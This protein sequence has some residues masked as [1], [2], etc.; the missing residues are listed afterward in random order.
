MADGL[1]P[2]ASP[3]EVTEDP[4]VTLKRLRVPAIGLLVLSGVT[5]IPG[6]FCLPVLPFLLVHRFIFGYLERFSY[7]ADTLEIALAIPMIIS[8]FAIFIGSWNMR[9]GRFYK[10]AYSAAVLSCIPFLSAGVY[11]GIPFGIWALIVLHRRDVKE[12]FA[13]NAENQAQKIAGHESPVG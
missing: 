10:L 6:I 11:L 12:A 8:N 9:R 5:A 13:R 7:K 1:N 2:Y 4:D 3:A